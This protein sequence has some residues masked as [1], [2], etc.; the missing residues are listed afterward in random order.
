MKL[1]AEDSGVVD[2]KC[3]VTSAAKF[4]ISGPA[5]NVPNA[6]ARASLCRFRQARPYC[7]F[8][9]LL[10]VLRCS[11]VSLKLQVLDFFRSSTQLPQIVDSGWPLGTMQ[12]VP[13][14]QFLQ[15]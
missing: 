10:C 9:A 4:G 1:V 3:S 2:C 11:C 12:R 8:P 7:R 13:E 6:D 15:L 14:G 5:K